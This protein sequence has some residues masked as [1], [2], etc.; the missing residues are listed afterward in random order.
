MSLIRPPKKTGFTLFFAL[1]RRDFSALLRTG[2]HTGSKEVQRRW[3]YI[4]VAVRAVSREAHPIYD[5]NGVK[6]G[7]KNQKLITNLKIF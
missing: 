4:F 1:V 2:V 6:M 3:G 5:E 7:T